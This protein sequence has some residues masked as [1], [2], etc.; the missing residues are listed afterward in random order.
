MYLHEVQNYQGEFDE[1]FWEV[2]QIEVKAGEEGAFEA[3]AGKAVPLFKRAK[4]CRG[5]QMQRSVEHPTRYLLV[6]DWETVEDHIVHFRESDDF[7]EWRRLVGEFFA[8]SP[9]VQHT[10]RLPLG[11]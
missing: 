5:M 1:M 3:A 7:R 2:A 6:V 9:S 11:F 8:S 4:G 10:R